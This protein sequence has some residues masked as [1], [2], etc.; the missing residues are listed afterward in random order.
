MLSNKAKADELAQIRRDCEELG[1]AEDKIEAL[2]FAS[3][4]VFE[5]YMTHAMETLESK[6]GSV[7]GYISK[8]LGLTP[9][10][11]ARLRELYTV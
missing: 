1:M 10:D 7:R 4:G 3:G 8:E 2:Q 11:L 5:H 9:E 6:Y